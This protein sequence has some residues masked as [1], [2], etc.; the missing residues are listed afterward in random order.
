M[1]RKFFQPGDSGAIPELARKP[2]KLL[3]G[4]LA[5]AVLRRKSQNLFLEDAFLTSLAIWGTF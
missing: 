2:A 1:P 3:M 5:E 4:L